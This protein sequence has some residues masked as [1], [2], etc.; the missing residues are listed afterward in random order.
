[1]PTVSLTPQRVARGKVS[2]TARNLDLQRPLTVVYGD[3]I[4]PRHGDLM[5]ATVVTLGQH[6]KLELT[7]GRRATLYLGDEVIVAA[8]TRYA[9]NQFEAEL[10]EDLGPCDLVAAGG[11]AART[12]SAHTAMAAPTG[13][14]PIGL[15]ADSS[16]A[17]INLSDLALPAPVPSLRRP[18]TLLVVGTSM[19]SGKTTA[20]AAFTRGLT[21]AGLRVGAAKLT[22]TG[23]G[24][25]RWLYHDAGA[26]E[27]L[28]FTDAGLAST[29]RVGLPVLLDCVTSLHA[30]LAG[31]GVGAIVLEISD[32]V[33]QPETAALLS[34][35][36]MRALADGVL[37]TAVDAAGAL[38]GVQQLR[39]A[40]L[41][42]LAV[43]GLLT[44][45]PLAVREAQDRLDIPVYGTSELRHP[46]LAH[47]VLDLLAAPAT[48][49]G[50]MEH[51]A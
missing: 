48:A 29:Y 1:M 13:L 25:D 33:L 35:P 46:V 21:A 3:D 41:P 24:G 16:G 37:F 12:R 42:V 36:R 2:Y 31:R 51:S 23:A 49:R 39:A 18:P 28:D 40:G 45:A 26:A 10:P 4:A 34:Q 20:G 19:S 14:R 8:S 44:A 5:L 47:D 9:P 30:H 27:V 50:V 7:N 15:L 38:L 11:I 32:G 22:G 17:V 43:T 6:A